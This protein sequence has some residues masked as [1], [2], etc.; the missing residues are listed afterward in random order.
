MKK[1]L[2]INILLFVVLIAVPLVAEVLTAKP[3]NVPGTGFDILLYQPFDYAYVILAGILF[4]ALNS[5]I[6]V[7]QQHSF[8]AGI[9]I[10]IAI[11]VVWFVVT[12]LSVSQLHLSLGGKL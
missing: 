10:G 8:L 2:L 3:D 9:G 4:I 12:F 6:S 11:L 7:Q 1:R 5:Y